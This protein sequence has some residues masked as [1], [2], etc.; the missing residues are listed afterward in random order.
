[1]ADFI[2]DIK[3]VRI[4][5]GRFSGG[6]DLDLFGG[7]ASKR[8]RASVIIGR[9]GS[10]KTTIANF[11]GKQVGLPD[12]PTCFYGYDHTPIALAGKNAVRVFSEQYIREKILIDEDGLEAIVMLGDQAA[13]S[14]R[15]SE[16]DS[17]LTTL[18]EAATEYALAKEEA[19]N[20][21]ASLAK[22]EKAA[23]DRAK[24]GAWKERLARIEGGNPSLTAM[25]WEA[26][27][28][29][30]NSAAR[31]ELEVEF[32]TLLEQYKRVE[33]AGETIT[34]GYPISHSTHMTR[35]VSAFF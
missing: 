17:E 22:L 15:I 18:G 19:T 6:V 9:N 30:K 28:K 1:M 14:K 3:G 27:L 11:I 16:I 7:D 4:D 29:A 20:G 5:A 32:E 21:P 10:G 34:L 23:K 26:I 35:R 24:N 2:S 25:R 13:A 12:G 31:K 33:S 8:H